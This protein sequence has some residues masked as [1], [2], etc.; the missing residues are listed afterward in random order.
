MILWNMNFG[1]LPTLVENRDERAAYS[2]LTHLKPQQE[3]PLYWMIYDATQPDV[4]LDRY[5]AG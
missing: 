5:D 1:W 3:R 4:Q 2:L